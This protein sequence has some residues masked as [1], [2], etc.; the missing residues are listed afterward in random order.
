MDRD[1]YMDITS[2]RPA[3][4]YPDIFLFINNTNAKWPLHV[5]ILKSHWKHNPKS[6]STRTSNG[7]APRA[8]QRRAPRGHAAPSD[9]RAPRSPGSRAASTGV[10]RSTPPALPSP[11]C[12]SSY[13]SSPPLLL[14]SPLP[15]F[16]PFCLLRPFPKP[17]CRPTAS[18]SRA[19]HKVPLPYECRQC[20]PKV[21]AKKLSMAA[22]FWPI[23][24]S[25]SNT[26]LFWIKKCKK[27]K[28][29]YLYI[30]LSKMVWILIS[31]IQ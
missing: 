8:S 5:Q 23:N 1:R 17:S 18:P 3:D 28:E 9:A 12:P 6:G 10:G 13:L 29:K 20:Y 7:A 16:L 14:P 24:F 4:R 15:S 2:I 30:R 19:C 27:K 26:P 11:L 25:L 21:P 31:F 22:R